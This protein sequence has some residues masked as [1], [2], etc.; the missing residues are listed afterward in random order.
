MSYGFEAINESGAV[1]VRSGE[2][3]LK[4]VA[5]G[6][7]TSAASR[8]D[9]RST[10]DGPAGYRM[11]VPQP[12]GTDAHKCLV[13]IQP[14][15]RF[16]GV[17]A[18]APVRGVTNPFWY[19]T[20]TPSSSFNYLVFY[21][22]HD[23]VVD[24]GDTWGIELFD[25]NGVKTFSSNQEIL[26]VEGVIQERQVEKQA[27]WG[28]YYET[29]YYH[30]YCLNAFYCLHMGYIGETF[31]EFV[32]GGEDGFCHRQCLRQVSGTVV[33]RNGYLGITT[34]R[35]S[36]DQSSVYYGGYFGC[37]DILLLKDPLL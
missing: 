31:S 28:T 26:D 18:R 13:F 34:H 37:Q 35:Y 29:E 7:I 6:S 9:S 12:P 1:V 36:I 17:D 25:A 8:W 33:E 11:A 24:A 19:I 2:T 22:T 15:N 23:G 14:K 5:Y 3:V 32:A 30:T 16:V 20:D 21:P 4:L 27:S 10:Y